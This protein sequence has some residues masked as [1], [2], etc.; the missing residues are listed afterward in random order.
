MDR[1][2]DGKIEVSGNQCK[3]GVAYAR[4]EYLDPRRV[5]TGTCAL[6]GGGAARL[7]VKSSM[8]VPID[9]LAPF[10]KAMYELRLTAPVK[11]GALIASDLGD[12]G[13]DLLA[14]MTAEET[15]E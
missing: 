15:H 6:S 2:A 5:V 7:P 14:T 8:G 12:T 1:P 11:R 13:I 3:R 10:L 4:E 9:D